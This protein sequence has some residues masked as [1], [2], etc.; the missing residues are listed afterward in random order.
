MGAFLALDIAVGLHLAHTV[1]AGTLEE[2]WR[3]NQEYIR[4]ACI[5]AK[6]G[7][8][9][10][11]DL[12]GED[13]LYILS[14]L[15]EPPESSYNIY[16]ITIYNDNTEKVVYIG[17]TDSVYGRFANGHLAALKLHNPIYTFYQKRVYFGTVTLLSKDKD[18]IPLEFVTPLDN[19]KK[20]LSEAEAFLINRL[21]PE[22]NKRVEPMGRFKC[23]DHLHIQNF[24]GVSDFMKDTIIWQPQFR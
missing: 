2:S 3:K 17:K 22:L 14:E 10:D 12:D 6:T 20:Y 7:K 9:N 4:N 16:F 24:S 15:G 11:Y 18:Y 8:E 19:A 23:I 13:K 5:I 1:S 21:K